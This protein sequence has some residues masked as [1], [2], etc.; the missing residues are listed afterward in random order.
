MV[1]W[2][3]ADLDCSS[4]IQPQQEM[5]T[6]KTLPLRNWISRSPWRCGLLFIPLALF[7]ALA[8]VAQAA[9]PAAP[10]AM[11]TPCPGVTPAGLARKARVSAPAIP[12][13]TC[14]GPGC[15]KK[16]TIFNNT[17]GTIWVAIQA[18][19]Q[20]P[21][22][23]L[24]ALFGNNQQSFAETH[25]SRV[26]PNYP[27]GIP[28]GGHLRVTVPWY[29]ELQGDV[30]QYVDW[31]NGGR[32]VIFDSFEAVERAHDQDRNRPLTV[33]GNS[34]TFCCEGCDA[35]PT[36]YADPVGTMTRGFH[37][38]WR[39]TPLSMLRGTHPTSLI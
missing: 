18:G 34:P 36:I 21:D 35:A 3:R 2:F 7:L 38:N 39:N 26:Y 22:P 33:T 27:G 24:Q 4:T 37:S 28:V 1:P 8:G 5:K 25:L 31:F 10:Q 19:F 23:W 32:V 14:P 13:P 17:N 30:D 9:R 29:S 20:N 11:C 6:A 12:P 15:E 16:I